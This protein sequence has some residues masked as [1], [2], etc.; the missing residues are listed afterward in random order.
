MLTF[1]FRYLCHYKNLFFSFIKAYDNVQYLSNHI[2][3]TNPNFNLF[4]FVA[5]PRYNRQKLYVFKI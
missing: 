1:N 2:N 3:H 4:S 5:I